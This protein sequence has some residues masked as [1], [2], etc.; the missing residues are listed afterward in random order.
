MITR[1]SAVKNMATAMGGLAASVALGRPARATGKATAFA[2][3]GDRY[4]NSD[5]L[6]TG[7]GKT[8]GKDRGLSIDFCD[9]VKLLTAEHLKDYRL[10][11]ILRDGMTWPNG[12]SDESSNAGYVRTGSPQ[13]VSE[14][15]VPKP[16]GKAHYWITA[17]QG[18][19]V[20]QFV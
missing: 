16:E 2:L 6:R 9:E 15:P 13:I 18:R 19:A 8:L 4:H 10:L 20:K 12:Y 1:R 17:D 3:I 11:I 7:L 14:P 5:Y